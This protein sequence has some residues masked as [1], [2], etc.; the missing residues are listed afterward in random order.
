MTEAQKY[1]RETYTDLA[2]IDN[3]EDVKILINTVDQSKASN[4]FWIG[5]YDD[6]N[7]WRWSLSNTSFYRDGEAEFRQSNNGEP[8]NSDSREHCTAMI[9]GQWNDINCMTRLRSVCMDVRGLNVTFVLIETLMNWTEAQSY[10]REHHTD[11]ASVRNMIENQKVADLVPAGQEAWIGFTETPGS[12]RMEATPHLGTGLKVNLITM[13]VKMLV[14][15][16][17]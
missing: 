16:E 1:C 14:W 6:L 17:V 8:N 4:G 15:W 9:D 3:M 2:T 12:G 7:S 13:V 5:L 11:L 10:C